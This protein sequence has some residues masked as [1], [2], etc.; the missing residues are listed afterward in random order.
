[1]L[2]TAAQI[3]AARALIRMDGKVLAERAGVA[4]STIRRIETEVHKPSS[5]VCQV[6]KAV[7]EQAGVEFIENGVKA[8]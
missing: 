5:A 3:R 2:I 1:M 8:K 4:I 7:L 6:I